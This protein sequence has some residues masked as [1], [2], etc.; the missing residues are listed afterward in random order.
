MLANFFSKSKPITFVVLSTLFLLFLI[1]AIFNGLF[2]QFYTENSWFK[3]IWYILLIVFNF[4][5]FNFI[6]TKNNLTFDNA[7]AF[8]FFIL[9]LGVI[10]AS[11]LNEKTLTI[12]LVLLLFLR[13]VY[14]LQSPK[15][16]IQKL[17]D[18]GFWLGISFLIEPFTV[19]FGVLLYVS[20]YL[21]KRASYQALL[22]PVIGFAAP[23]FL[24]FTYCFW[25]GKL[26]EFYDHFYWY[27]HYDFNAYQNLKL[28]IPL[29]FTI[30]LTLLIAF[31]KSLKALPVKNVFRKNWLLILLNFLVAVLFILLLKEH[32]GSEFLYLF[33]PIA[34]ILANG[35]ELLKKQ[36]LKD[37]FI[38]LFFIS[39]ILIG[40]L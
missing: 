17:F 25:V 24:Y 1:F 7:Y 21:H 14:S 40:F 3:Y 8:L 16:S 13:K 2:I 6:N 9:C 31:L 36:W 26:G 23:L 12:N 22:V 27:T 35:M 29:G 34:I 15:N 18:G 5:F 19:L 11:F 32:N 38:G 28:L 30:I 10:P 4:F 39:G 20:M 37:V 33:F